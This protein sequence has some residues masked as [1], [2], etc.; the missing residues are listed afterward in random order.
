MALYARAN[1]YGFL[2]TPYKKVKID[3][4]GDKVVA[5]VT[6]EVDYLQAD[7][8]EKYY[9]TS[10]NV[11]LNEKGIIT[12]DTVVARHKGEVIEIPTEKVDYID[13]S[14]RQAI[15]ISAAMIP[16]IQNDDASRALMG[17]HMQCQA[18][19]LIKPQAPFV[20]TGMEEIVAKELG[21]TIVAPED[22][23][24]EYVDGEKVTFKGESGKKHEYKLERYVRTNRD[25][26][27]DQKPRVEPK[28]K[29][30]KG[31]LIVDGPTSQ[32]G[33]LALG[34][35]LV[36]AY[37]SLKGLGYEDGFVIS[38]R[39]LKDD[40]FTSI[41]SEEYVADVVDTKL[42]PEELTRDL[43]N[44]REEV[45]QNLDKDGNVLLGTHV[46]GGD[47]LVGK[48]AP[49]GERELTAEER[50]LRAIFGEKA[51]D[52]KD[53]SL[54]MPYGDRGTVVNIDTINAKKDPN[55]LEP[56][57]IERILVRTSQLRKITVG[58]KLAGRHGNKGVIAKI[59][60]AE[61]M[62]F[63]EDGT[64]V[65]M[66]LNPLG[67][68]SRLN[69]GQLFEVHLGMAAKALGYKVATPAFNGV[70]IADVKAQLKKAG[71]PEDGKQMLIDGRTG[72][73]FKERVTVGIM[74][75]IKLHH[76]I[77]DK[78]H[79]RSIGPYTM[80][81]QQPLGG[82]AQNGGQRFGEMEVWA[83]EAYG[84]AN[85][86]QEMLTLKSDDVFGR[87]KA[88]ESII[89]QEPIVGP[90][91]PESFNV[92]V[93]ELQGLSLRVDLMNSEVGEID[94]EDM[95]EA[96]TAEDA[97]N[98]P[99]GIALDMDPIDVTEEMVASEFEIVDEPV[100]AVADDDD[101]DSTDDADDNQQDSKQEEA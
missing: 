3:K 30:K 69:I 12:G 5:T 67:I 86:L 34:Q 61:D 76:M 49:K 42:G 37:T 38:E 13:V 1:E 41:S 74:H 23:T 63:L 93:K 28:Q 33:R 48:V 44:V 35:N 50:L 95:L 100:A 64:P 22:G 98:A 51:K 55:E 19:P 32:H 92:L 40:V 83:L 57:I 6:N 91:I 90:K 25:V 58:D 59:V 7:D 82:K 60:P 85:T 101:D 46:K 87:S 16:F 15:G 81:T 39:L 14:P 71:L 80:V 96:S 20:G 8:E 89:K 78:I 66:V 68:P 75:I 54:K 52:V 26:S 45:L 11:A 47:I 9:I 70:D 31:D 43:P 84:A 21:R 73:Y 62:P 36:I 99:E 97:L 88:Y 10:A 17:S 27:F 94:A 4:K 24:I 18:V 79:A 72:E 65:D 2:E 29:L 77:A 53:T 56:S